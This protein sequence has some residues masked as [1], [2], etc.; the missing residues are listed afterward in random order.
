MTPYT[1][2]CFYVIFASVFTYAPTLSH[3]SSRRTTANTHHR[4]PTPSSN[5]G[6][7]AFVK[8]SQTWYSLLSSQLPEL[9]R[10]F[11]R[12]RPSNAR[13]SAAFT[14]VPPCHG[15][16][17]L[18]RRTCRRTFRLHHR[19]SRA[20]YWHLRCRNCLPSIRSLP[21]APRRNAWPSLFALLLDCI[22]LAPKC[23]APR[24]AQKSA[25]KCAKTLT[26]FASNPS[27]NSEPII[28]PEL[29]SVNYGLSRSSLTCAVP[30]WHSLTRCTL[31]SSPHRLLTPTTPCTPVSTTTQPPHITVPSS[32]L[33]TVV[34]HFSLHP[35]L[36]YHRPSGDEFHHPNSVYYLSPSSN[37]SM[38]I[39]VAHQL[40]S[41]TDC[42]HHYVSHHQTTTSPPPLNA[43]ISR[44][45][46]ARSI[47]NGFFTS[48]SKSPKFVRSTHNDPC[49][50]QCS[51][52]NPS[53]M[54]VPMPPDAS[55]SLNPNN[56]P[57]PH[58]NSSSGM[59]TCLG[60][61]QSPTLKSPIQSSW[62]PPSSPPYTP[63][64]TVT[65]IQHLKNLFKLSNSPIEATKPP[66]SNPPS[67][68]SAW[69]YLPSDLKLYQVTKSLSDI[70][71]SDNQHRGYPRCCKTRV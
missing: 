61:N 13:V 65:L 37:E 4:R 59:S 26:S 19:Q 52:A 44:I 55:T 43:I 60:P 23:A 57:S 36:F 48:N 46:N 69:P 70:M 58:P 12:G 42:F 63:P 2:Y 71:S 17:Q 41:R 21:T 39:P 35:R 50:L 45:K 24:R 28:K 16:K 68:T 29:S 22:G 15:R 67:T 10:C 38:I 64:L 1:W 8:T 56:L 3:R 31:V 62:Q 66:P 49:R 20:A 11:Q 34:D 51:N 18:A 33:K 54:P 40:D 47:F 32:T 9:S 6:A 27:C 5:F 30:P 7:S 53:N 14:L 25:P